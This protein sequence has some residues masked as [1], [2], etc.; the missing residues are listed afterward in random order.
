MSVLT[1]KRELATLASIGMSGRQTRDMLRDEG[2]GYAIITILCSL[3]LC[4]SIVYGLFSLYKSAADYAQFTYPF[5]PVMAIYA[6]IL[7]VCFITPVNAY[8]DSI[9][10]TLVERLRE[11]E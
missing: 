9:K 7:L 2:L 11:T 1:R 5:I 6:V 3:T 10:M 4:N 8:K